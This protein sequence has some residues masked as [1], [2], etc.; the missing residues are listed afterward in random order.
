[1]GDSNK[2]YDVI[3]LYSHSDIWKVVK[4]FDRM[5]DH[6]VEEIRVL[7]AAS[8]SFKSKEE[9]REA[10]SKVMEKGILEKNSG[11]ADVDDDSEVG[12]PLILNASHTTEIDQIAGFETI[13]KDLLDLR[14]KMLESIDVGRTRLKSLN[15][16]IHFRGRAVVF[17]MDPIWHVFGF[18]YLFSPEDAA[19]Y[20]CTK[21]ECSGANSFPFVYYSI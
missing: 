19:E 8:Q 3:I 11:D 21:G 16:D 5:Y 18:K 9:F 1:M 4:W 14:I 6:L 10:V 15:L 12:L 20:F 13:V 17:I 2:D 7:N